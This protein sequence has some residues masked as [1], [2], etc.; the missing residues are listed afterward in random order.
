MLVQFT[1]LDHV[2]SKPLKIFFVLSF[3]TLSSSYNIYIIT[4]Y[5]QL[6]QQLLFVGY[7]PLSTGSI[8]VLRKCLH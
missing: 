8:F 7:S 4:A 1:V 2:F 5:S 3:S 6:L